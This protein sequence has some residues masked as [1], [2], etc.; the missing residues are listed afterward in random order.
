MSSHHRHKRLGKSDRLTLVAE[1]L[2]RDNGICQICGEDTISLMQTLL[3]IASLNRIGYAKRL[4]DIDKARL[5]QAIAGRH[6]RLWDIDHLQPIS[7][8]GPTT[9]TNLRTLCIKCHKRINKQ[10]ED[11]ERTE[12]T[13]LL[14]EEVG[15]LRAVQGAE[16][17]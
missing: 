4:Y 11:A 10:K 8:D 16:R 5:K 3:R 7:E 12:E 1:L 9:L 13:S 2:E 17:S 6:G 15:D 14:R